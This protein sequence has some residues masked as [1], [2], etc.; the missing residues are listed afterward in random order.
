MKLIVIGRC[1]RRDID[2][3][4]TQRVIDKEEFKTRRTDPIFWKAEKRKT[5]PLLEHCVIESEF[6][7]TDQQPERIHT[8]IATAQRSAAPSRLRRSFAATFGTAPKDGLF[9][10]HCHVM[11]RC[12]GCQFYSI[13]IRY[14]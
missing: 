12:A 4:S 10:L 13:S 2:A 1:V 6:A 11:S 9:P 8:P 5:E 7:S 14:N 3:N